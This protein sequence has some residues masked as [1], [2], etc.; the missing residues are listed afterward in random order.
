MAAAP[1]IDVSHYTYRVTW[2]AEDAEHVAT[3]AEFPSLSWLAPTPQD[4]LQGMADLISSTVADMTAAGEDVP[5]PLAD[6][7]Y[8]G[9]F[10]VRI[11]ESLHRT[12]SLRA[13]EEHVSLNQYVVRML[14]ANP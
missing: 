2:S 7:V 13:A 3:V 8:S 12:L 1:D 10:N 4:A 6:R 9:R 11:G 5:L 14:S